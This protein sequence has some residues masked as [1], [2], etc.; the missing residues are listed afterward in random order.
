MIEDCDVSIV[1]LFEE[2][3]VKLELRVKKKGVELMF[4]IDVKL[5]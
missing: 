2:Y 4:F 5:D 1:I 3:V